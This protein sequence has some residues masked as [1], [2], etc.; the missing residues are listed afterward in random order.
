MTDYIQKITDHVK[1]T[2]TPED[3]S[4]KIDAEQ[5]PRFVMIEICNR[6]TDAHHQNPVLWRKGHMAEVCD[7]A[8]RLSLYAA[9]LSFEAAA[10]E[11]PTRAR[12]DGV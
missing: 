4:L 10:A 7:M 12:E 11:P 8:A 1:R 5:D 9:S 2:I 3:I 6:I